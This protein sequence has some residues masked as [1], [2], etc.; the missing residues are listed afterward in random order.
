MSLIYCHKCYGATQCVCETPT[1]KSPPREFWIYQDKID[2]DDIVSS[3]EPQYEKDIYTH[4]IEH[5]AYLAVK[6][7]CAQLDDHNNRLIDESCKIIKERDKLQQELDAARAE[8]EAYKACEFT[9]A[10]TRR[11]EIIVRQQLADAQAL[12]TQAHALLK[13]R[14]AQIKDYESALS[15]T[16]PGEFGAVVNAHHKEAL[17]KWRAK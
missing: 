9:W 5:S 6:E 1:D 12:F 13:S 2:H 10:Q 17:N 14:D 7:K 16:W 4:V 8:V 11:T 3:I 15:E